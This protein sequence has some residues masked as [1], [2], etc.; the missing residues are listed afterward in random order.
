M[1]QFSFRHQGTLWEPQTLVRELDVA[2]VVI[3]VIIIS[4]IMMVMMMI[5]IRGTVLY[6]LQ[7]LTWIGTFNLYRIQC[8]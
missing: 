4:I 8:S 3:T 6:I 1:N 5:M 7:I 2:V